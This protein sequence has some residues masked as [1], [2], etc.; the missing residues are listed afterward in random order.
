M[1]F[2][3]LEGLDRTGK[4][5]VAELYKK[6]GY[7][8]VH[9]SA[10]DKKYTEDGY[11]GPSYLDDVLD[12]IMEYDGRDVVWDRSWYGELVWPH[13]YGRKPMLDDE[14][15]EI[16]NEF[17]ERN[18]VEKILMVD[19]DTESHWKRCVENKEPLNRSQ[20]MVA[21][22]LFSKLAHKHGFMPRELKDFN[23]HPGAKG[24]DTPLIQEEKSDVERKDTSV[25][26]TL[27][28]ADPIKTV[29]KPKETTNQAQEKLERAN[30]I[31]GILSKRIVRQRGVVYD[32][33][34]TEIRSYLKDQLALLLGGTTDTSLTKDEIQVLKV[35]CERLKQRSSE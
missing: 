31:N 22:Q 20:F 18:Q 3:I 24:K 1:A 34:D 10:P 33:L 4:S 14:A 13:V 26:S 5:T 11:T 8:V 17:E 29:K 23:E 25:D 6:Q 30:A 28:A 16:I 19:P 32:K 12:M 15:L 7:E 35:F 9:L 21:N 2:I 27:P